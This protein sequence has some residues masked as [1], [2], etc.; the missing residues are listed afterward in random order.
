[1][2]LV[3]LRFQDEFGVVLMCIWSIELIWVSTYGKMEEKHTFWAK[4][5]GL[6]LYKSELYRY[7]SGA[8]PVQVRAVPIQVVFCFSILTSVRML[9]ITCSFLI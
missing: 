3:K 1:M 8:V 7:S 4:F 6:Y 2:N 9:A 5:E